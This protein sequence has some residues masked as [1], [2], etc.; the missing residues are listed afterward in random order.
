MN[1]KGLRADVLLLMTALIWGLG[2]VAQHSG[3]EYIGPF[4]YNG[5]RFPLGALSLVPLMLYRRVTITGMLPALLAGTCLFLAVSLQQLG[6]M[7]TTAGNAGFI[8]GLYVIFVPIAGILWGRKT[9]KATWIGAIFAAIGLYCISFSGG[10]SAL[11]PGDII[12]VISALFWTVHVLLIDHLMQKSHLDPIVLSAGQFAWCGLFSLLFAFIAEP[13]IP[14]WVVRFFPAQASTGLLQ[15]TSLGDLLSSSQSGE[16]IRG[17]LIPVLYGGLG[18]V[19]IAYTLQVVAQRD[20]PP[21]H[22]TIIL[23][24]EGS[25]AALG[26]IVILKEP[27]EAGTIV[28]FILMLSGMIIS[29]RETIG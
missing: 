28:G 24:L 2:F 21:A 10:S 19:G 29:Q 11:N 9:G 22:A 15:W 12:M 13:L 20:A 18:S 16:I 26:G 5:I 14:E 3:M 8:T 6:M 7:V 1:T 4:S 23:C 17:A 25:F 27:V